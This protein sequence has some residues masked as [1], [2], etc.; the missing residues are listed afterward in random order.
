MV[1]TKGDKKSNNKTNLTLSVDHAILDEIKKDS[2]RQGLSI[3]AKVSS[4]LNKYVLFY[5][6]I[7]DQECSVI[8][9]RLWGPMVQ[10]VDE[11][12]MLDLINNEGIGAIYSIFLNNNVP[13]TLDTFIKHCFEEICLW[14]GLYHSFRMFREGG[15]LILVFEHKYGIKWS[16]IIGNAFTNMIRIMLNHR[17]D[18]Q[19]LPNTVRITVQE[20]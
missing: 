10:M 1:E 12:K 7:E 19:V 4:V 5:R 6:I 14:S 15:Q 13:M 8:P 9:S 16:R 17:A 2:E 20:K 18:S 11:E 3:N